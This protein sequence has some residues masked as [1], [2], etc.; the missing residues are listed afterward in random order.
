[1]AELLSTS[2]ELPGASKLIDHFYSNNI[3]MAICTGSDNIEFSQKTQ[4]FGHWLEKIKLQVLSGSDPEVFNGKPHP[5]PYLV[6]LSRFEK[7]PASPKNV[8]FKNK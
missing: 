8:R 1:M 5:D 4:N 3:P 2:S 7:L 6:T